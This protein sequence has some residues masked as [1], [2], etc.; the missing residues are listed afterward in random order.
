MQRIMRP[1]ITLS[2]SRTLSVAWALIFLSRMAAANSPGC[3]NPPSCIWLNTVVEG[4]S[5]DSFTF[6]DVAGWDLL[7]R[8]YY[9]CLYSRVLQADSRTTCQDDALLSQVEDC[10]ADAY[11]KIRPDV[12]LKHPNFDNSVQLFKTCMANT[13][14]KFRE[15]GLS[16]LRGSRNIL[17]Q[18]LQ[19]AMPLPYISKPNIT[20]EYTH[21]V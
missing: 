3:T 1:A 9:A 15:S 8:D 10:R 16:S 20:L 13:V 4:C 12:K 7:K 5:D 14:G 17:Q 18:P 21:Y 19:R 11:H 2:S 6:K